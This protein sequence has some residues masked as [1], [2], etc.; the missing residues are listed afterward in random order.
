MGKIANR[1][2]EALYELACEESKIDL[3]QQQM[4]KVKQVFDQD[5]AIQAFFSHIRID[6]IE[7]RVV[8]KK[9]FENVIDKEVLNFLFVLVD[10]NRMSQFQEIAKRFHTLC[11]VSKGIKEGFIYSIRPL[12]EDEIQGIEQSVSNKMAF[13]VNLMNRID[14]SLISGIR[15]VVEDIV[16][17]GS[18]KYRLSSLK[19][20]LLKGSR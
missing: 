8:L 14:Q 16:I 19:T 15:V 6:D 10:K 3:W 13:R 20:E 18:M 11:N 5:V 9:V 2:A 12:S 17:D 4:R 7:K 1:Y